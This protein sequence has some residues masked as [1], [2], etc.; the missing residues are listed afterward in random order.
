MCDGLTGCHLQ[1]SVLYFSAK[2]T[3]EAIWQYLRLHEQVIKLCQRESMTIDNLVQ[4][5]ADTGEGR[6]VCG[7]Y[8]QVFR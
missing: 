6:L 8:E 5:H 4:P 7:E 1:F 3:A 2:Q